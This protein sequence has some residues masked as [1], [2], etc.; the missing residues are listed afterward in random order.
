MMAKRLL[1][2]IA[3]WALG[4]PLGLHHLYLGRDNHALLWMLTLG[5]FGFG[6]L[7]EL[8]LLPG[9]VAQANGTLEPQS[10]EQPPL[11]PV[12]FFGQAFVGIYFGLAALIALSALPGFYILALPLAVGLGVHLVSG[13]GNQASNLQ[14]TFTAAFVTSLIFY[15]RSVAILPISLI[16]SVTAQWHRHY[17]SSR[18]TSEKLS[19]RVYR[20]G[21]AYLAF[22]TPLAYCAF[23]NT[24]ATISSVA[25]TIGAALDYLNMF[26]LLGNM[27]ES[28]LLLPYR[29]WRM[30][31][32]SEGYFQEWEKVFVFVQSFQDERRQMAY[33]VLGIHEDATSEEIS[34]RYR[35]LVKLWHPD[36]NRHQAE[37]SE[38]RFLEVQA[39]YELLMKMKKSKHA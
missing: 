11:N 25:S 13:V 32:F 23:C 17:K 19:G 21:L 29:T 8:W 38:R 20:L 18:H 5:G 3:L 4:G 14:A 7:W 9:W 15:G 30:L 39:A 10:D 28:A 1:V 31:G 12:R 2:A 36:H 16:T 27:V 6:W 37:E 22:T 35:E 34:K 26:P 33:K 24:A